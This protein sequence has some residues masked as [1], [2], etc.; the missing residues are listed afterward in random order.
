MPGMTR[1]EIFRHPTC[2]LVHVYE[3]PDKS[4]IL[5]RQKFRGCSEDSLLHNQIA[6]SLFVPD[7]R[8]LFSTASPLDV[9]EKLALSYAAFNTDRQMN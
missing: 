4:P 5:M 7:E 3:S 6:V 9:F 8:L 1:N 2:I